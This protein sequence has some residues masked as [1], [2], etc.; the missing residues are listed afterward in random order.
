MLH[1]DWGK[2]LTVIGVIS[3]LVSSFGFLLWLLSYDALWKFIR[4]Q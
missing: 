4:R 2:L 3:T 1:L